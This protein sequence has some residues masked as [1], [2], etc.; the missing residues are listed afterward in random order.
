[1]DLSSSNLC[2]SRVNC[3]LRKKTIWHASKLI[4]ESDGN[5]HFQCLN[6]G[7]LE[8]F[9]CNKILAHVLVSPSL[10]IPFGEILG[11]RVWGFVQK[12]HDIN[13]KYS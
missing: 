2:C 11:A 4:H 3:T 8:R 12:Y 1:M 5:Q 7:V 10:K 13:C 6:S 9:V